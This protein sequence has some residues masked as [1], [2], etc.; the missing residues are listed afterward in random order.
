MPTEPGKFGKADGGIFPSPLIWTIGIGGAF[1]AYFFSLFMLWIDDLW[2]TL[3]TLFMGVISMVVFFLD[4]PERRSLSARSRGWIRGV[5]AGITVMALVQPAVVLTTG[6]ELAN[7]WLLAPIDMIGLVLLLFC[8]FV[9]LACLVFPFI[10][11]NRNIRE[12]TA[13]N[14]PST[15]N[16]ESRQA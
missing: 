1:V 6:G 16:V 2:A 4:N 7:P 12:A 13:R 11:I 5:S 10:A 14:R 9:V 3:I 8:L 15:A